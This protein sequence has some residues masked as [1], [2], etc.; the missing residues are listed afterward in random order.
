[1]AIVCMSATLLGLVLPSFVPQLQEA[2]LIQWTLIA[3]V[4]LLWGAA[5]VRKEWGKL[6][7][8]LL[9]SFC[10]AGALMICAWLVAMLGLQ[11]ASR[12][13][14]KAQFSEG[15]GASRGYIYDASLFFV[16]MGSAAGSLFM[17]YWVRPASDSSPA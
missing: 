10:G 16:L 14:P 1:M 7:A 8:M 5:V 11:V 17:W 6:R 12:V 15:F 4:V 2:Y 13:D 3:Q 9:A